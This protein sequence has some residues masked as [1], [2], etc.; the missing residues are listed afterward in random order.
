MIE[1]RVPSKTTL[2]KYG[3]TEEEWLEIVTSL[4]GV[5]SFC[6]LPAGKKCFTLKEGK[7]WCQACLMLCARKKD[8]KDAKEEINRQK[9]G[10][11]KCIK[12]G[13][14]KLLSEFPKSRK[15]RNGTPRYAYCKICHGKYQ[16]KQRLLWFFNLTEDDY[17][18]ILQH[19]D[20]K[21]ALCGKEPCKV[22]PSGRRGLRLA[23]DHDH[24]TGLIRGLLCMWCNR[25]T[26]FFRDNFERVEK[27]Y[28]YYKSPPAT[29][30]LGSPRF[31]LRGRVDNRVKT[32]RKLNKDV[33][34]QREELK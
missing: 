16:R 30:A 1:P 10:E 24:K 34:L 3:L 25:A 2:K 31:G 5:C 17:E 32:I 8:D 28:N 33:L 22:R 11:S 15:K 26:G 6:E 21:C 7:L 12:C 9:S 29:I 4:G 13:E 23:V 19:Q 27:A 18:K 14:V 20:G